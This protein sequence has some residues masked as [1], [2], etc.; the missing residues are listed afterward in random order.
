MAFEISNEMKW[1][2][3]IAIVAVGVII[4]WY[5]GGKKYEDKEMVG[6]AIGGVVGLIVAGGLYL[7]LGGE[8]FGKPT[9]TY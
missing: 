3:Y 1:I 7:F 2:L 5:V 8:L 4:G 9:M 6:M